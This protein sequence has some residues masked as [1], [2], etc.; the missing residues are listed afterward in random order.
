MLTSMLS[1]VGVYGHSAN[2]VLGEMLST[3]PFTVVGMVSVLVLR[4]PAPLV[5]P[6][7]IQKTQENKAGKD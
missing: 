3:F 4:H 1:R 7:A 2:R 5:Y 6:R